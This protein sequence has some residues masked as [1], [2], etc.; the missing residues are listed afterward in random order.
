MIPYNNLSFINQTYA[1]SLL[2][3]YKENLSPLINE[4]AQVILENANANNKKSRFDNI[5][6]FDICEFTDW[7]D[8]KSCDLS[9]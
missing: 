1:I 2:I 4:V 3:E 9:R 6:N 7:E 8:M 5:L